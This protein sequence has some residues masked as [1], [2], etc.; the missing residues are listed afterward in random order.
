MC[1]GLEV[2]AGGVGRAKP[3]AASSK[4]AACSSVSS[5]QWPEEPSL[6]ST[7]NEG[8]LSVS[9]LIY[10]CCTRIYTRNYDVFE[11]LRKR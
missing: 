6:A 5:S 7:L 11:E 10:I 3:L 2:R 1:P 4:A 8:N 9:V